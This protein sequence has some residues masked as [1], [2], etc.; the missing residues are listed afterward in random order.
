MFLTKECDYAMR[1]VRALADMEMKSVKSVCIVEHIPHP[2]AYKILKKLEHAGIV[3]SLRGSAGGYQLVKT[4][5]HI[6]L[7]DIVSA[8]DDHLLLNECLQPGY[9]CEN[10]THG[11]L[12]NVHIELNRLQ[13]LIENALSEKPMSELL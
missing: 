2:F 1:I 12:C 7:L 3:R 5:D 13:E 6:N 9:V 10:N 11:K 4:T 8:V